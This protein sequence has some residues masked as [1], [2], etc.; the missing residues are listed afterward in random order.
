[1]TRASGLAARMLPPPL[2]DTAEQTEKRAAM[3]QGHAPDASAGSVWVRT[4]RKA[5]ST[6][7]DRAARRYNQRWAG[8]P[9]SA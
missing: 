7:N 5:G 3:K 9:T 8:P 1:M 2:D 4:L 6:L